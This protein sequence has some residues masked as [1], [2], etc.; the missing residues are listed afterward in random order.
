MTENILIK[1]EKGKY[2]FLI[3]SKNIQTYQ[4]LYQQTIIN[5]IYIYQNN[6]YTDKITGLLRS[7]F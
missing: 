4:L 3:S 1:E 5:Y 7:K 6:G 2:D